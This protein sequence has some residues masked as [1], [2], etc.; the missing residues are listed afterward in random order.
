MRLAGQVVTV[1]TPPP[2]GEG[3]TKWADSIKTFYYIFINM[4]F[5][6]TSYIG[7][8]DMWSLLLNGRLPGDGS[9]MPAVR[10][11]FIGG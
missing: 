8:T 5:K 3:E 9:R 11:W 4:K 1:K 6:S 2:E 10:W 7:D